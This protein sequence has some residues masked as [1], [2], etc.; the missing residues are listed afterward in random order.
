MKECE[1]RNERRENSEKRAVSLRE[2]KE[3]QEVL[4]E[5]HTT[6]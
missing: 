3:V 1:E 2:R 4:R 6:R 5:E